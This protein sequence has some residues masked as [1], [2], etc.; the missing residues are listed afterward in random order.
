MAKSERKAYYWRDEIYGEVYITYAE[1]VNKARQNIA[2]DAGEAYF[3]VSPRRLPW[4]DKYGDVASVPD[5]V[6][7]EHGW[8]PR[9]EY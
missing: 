6:W 4:A 9:C 3:K 2:A 7:T 1:N 8:E 5:E